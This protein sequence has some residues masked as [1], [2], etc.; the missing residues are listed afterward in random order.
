MEPTWKNTF[1]SQLML[2]GWAG[3]AFKRAANA[4]YPFIA[5]NEWVYK[6][7][8]DDWSEDARL[9]LAEDLK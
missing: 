4:G 5:W 1:N 3:N 7:N 6:T 9:M 8:P 2:H